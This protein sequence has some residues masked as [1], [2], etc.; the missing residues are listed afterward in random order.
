[1]AKKKD[2]EAVYKVVAP[3]RD[4]SN[5]DVAYAAGQ[6]VSDLSDERLLELMDKGLVS[7][8]SES[9]ED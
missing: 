5:W 2:E 1:M 4:K 7:D 3:F 9:K 8:G 6:D